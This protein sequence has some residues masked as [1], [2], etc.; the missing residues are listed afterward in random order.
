MLWYIKVLSDS[1]LTRMAKVSRHGPLALTACAL[2]FRFS[3]NSAGSQ[4]RSGVFRSLLSR[5]GNST[6]MEM[7][8]EIEKQGYLLCKG[9]SSKKPSLLCHGLL[10]RKMNGLPAYSN[11][12]ELNFLSKMAVIVIRLLGAVF[13]K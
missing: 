3:L 1:K 8:Q 5:Y 12:L 10:N 2:L 7:E 6:R 4:L 11:T 9:L 13:D